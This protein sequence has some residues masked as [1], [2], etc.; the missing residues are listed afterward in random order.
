MYSSLWCTF[1]IRKVS[2]NKTW[3]PRIVLYSKVHALTCLAAKGLTLEETDKIFE[4]GDPIT[5]GAIGFRRRYVHGHP[6]SP[7]EEKDRETDGHV[8]K[9]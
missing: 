2:P 9:A 1:S 8:E 3:S 4:G 7:L 5:R 6:A